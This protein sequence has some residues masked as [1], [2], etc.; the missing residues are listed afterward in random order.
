MSK[1][2][3]IKSKSDPASSATR[4]TILDLLKRGGAQSANELGTSIGVTAMAVRLHLYELEEEGLVANQ[5]VPAG[6]GR[7]V[8]KWSLTDAASRVFPDAHQGLAVAMITAVEELF[9]SEG[10]EKIVDKHG[11][12]QR[13]D[14]REKL[15]G[16][17]T[18]ASRVKCLAA[19]RSEEGYMAEA[20]QEGCDW[21]LI[22][23]H[24]PVCSAAKICKGL[25]ANE[26]KVFQDV[27]G[28]D[29][30]V[31]REEHLLSGARRCTYRVTPN[32]S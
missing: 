30:S 29:V 31:S 24:C 5:S 25:C 26:L 15:D 28:D 4:R 9:G 7:P 20:I 1:A 16:M 32:A 3:I 27:L 21:I 14:Y 10:L 22:E 18:I 19:S 11:D 17:E 2:A 8:K 13:A 6:R 23:N 12:L